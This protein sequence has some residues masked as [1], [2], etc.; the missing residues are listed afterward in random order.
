MQ[1]TVEAGE[2]LARRMTVELPADDVEQQV[3]QKLREV[4]RQA[5]LPGFR[6]GKVPMR[7]L[8]QRFGEN[9]RGEVLG[10]MVQSTFPQ[11]VAEQELRLAGQ[12]QIEPD[13]DAESGRYAYV[14]RFEVLPEIDLHD[15]TGKR[16]ARPVAEVADADVDRMIERLREQRRTFEDVE[17]PAQSGD[18]LTI[19]FTGSID[20]EPFEGGSGEHRQLVLGSGTFIP[21]FEEQLEGASAGDERVVEVTFP[22]DYQN[23]ELAGRAAQFQVSVEAVAEPHLPDLDADFM[24]AFGIEDGDFEHFRADV[25]ANMERELKQRI[26]SNVKSQ[27]L[28]ALLEANPVDLPAALI[29]EE[30]QSLKQ[31]TLQSA[32]G[33]DIDLP[34]ELFAESAARRVKLGLVVAEVVKRY[35]LKPS[36]ERVRELVEELAATYERP[37]DFIRYHY[38]DQQRLAAVESLAMEELVV[39]RML[40]TAEVEE[41]SSSFDALTESSDG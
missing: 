4:A 36:E 22:E 20:G 1:V 10:E 14:A 26:Q 9:V 41:E 38:A 30:I 15:L 29:N 2:G 33:V 37:E 18:R 19:S 17:R 6:P 11:A 3:D 24:T 39:E 12:P 32:G 8:R 21:G 28:D 27:V 5:R 34:N 16:I 13:I 40:E 7:V 23:S 25:R 31:Q 35:E